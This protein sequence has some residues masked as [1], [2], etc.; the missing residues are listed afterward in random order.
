MIG[1][2]LLA[3]L[4]LLGGL[5]AVDRT[6]F[7][8]SM[9]SR[10]LAGATLAGW[11]VG[12]PLLGLACGAL[13]E[14]LWLM[15]LPMGAAVP[16]DETLVGVLAPVFAALA[17][18]PWSWE[19][20]AS[21]GVLLAVPFGA[22][23]RRLDILVRRWNAGLLDSVRR[24]LAEGRE[25]GLGRRHLAGA[26]R[27]FAAGAAATGTGAWA[28]SWAIAAVAERLPGETGAGLELLESSLPFLGA[29]AVLAGLGLRRHAPWFTLGA[30]G[31]LSA[32]RGGE[33]LEHLAGKSW[34]R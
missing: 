29:A 6:A 8:Q 17:P 11:L 28:G 10:P 9:V 26:L 23:G 31:A 12:A 14:L 22:L 25:P 4:S 34:R 33:L 18:D 7:L 3:E 24:D 19:A 32:Q 5:L 21:L 30:L 2:R 27:F 20:R 16:P 1:P 13:V 15:D